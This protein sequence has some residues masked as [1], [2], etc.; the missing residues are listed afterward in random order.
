MAYIFENFQAVEPKVPVLSDDG[1]NVADFFAVDIVEGKDFTKNYGG[2]PRSDIAA[3]RDAQD[4][5]MIQ[6]LLDRLQEI[7]VSSPNSG[8]SD[9]QI[10]KGIRSK[11][12]QTATEVVAYIENQIKLRDLDRM[13]V[14]NEPPSQSV[15]DFK[16]DS[17]SD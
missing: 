6:G 17:N 2:S 15:I 14:A 10:L 7:S 13:E 8:K 5:V 4:S 3:L 16:E 9:L 1:S 12:S 11:Y